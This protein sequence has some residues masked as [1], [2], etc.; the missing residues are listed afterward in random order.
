MQFIQNF[1]IGATYLKKLKTIFLRYFSHKMHIN[2]NLCIKSSYKYLFLIY[3]HLFQ[4]LFYK[5]SIAYIYYNIFKS[6]M[7]IYI[8]IN[9]LIFMVFI[10]LSQ[11]FLSHLNYLSSDINIELL[12][13]YLMKN[14]KLLR[15]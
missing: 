12:Y 4:C 5:L 2:L 14:T 6:Y 7:N 8:I 11:N 9:I 15:T 1:L 10:L 3:L 13:Y